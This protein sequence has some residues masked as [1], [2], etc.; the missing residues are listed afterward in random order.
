MGKHTDENRSNQLNPNNDAYWEAR[1]Y[2]GRPDDW[3]ERLEDDE[4]KPDARNR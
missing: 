1:G 3:T 4:D 2:E